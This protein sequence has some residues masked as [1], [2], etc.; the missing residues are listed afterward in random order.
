LNEEAKQETLKKDLIARQY[1]N[2][3]NS[4]YYTTTEY[5]KTGNARRFLSLPDKNP[6]GP[7]KLYKIPA[8][9]TVLRGKAASQ[10]L[11]WVRPRFS[12]HIRKDR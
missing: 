7:G 12:G 3:E 11:T 10:K 4:P 6:G 8:G 1:G 2:P 9:T 5:V